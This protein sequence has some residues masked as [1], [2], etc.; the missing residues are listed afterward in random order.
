M[1]EFEIDLLEIL[2]R[3]AAAVES[4]AKNYKVSKKPNDDKKHQ[5]NQILG[6]RKEPDNVLTYGKNKDVVGTYMVYQDKDTRRI[7][8]KPR[9]PLKGDSSARMWLVNQ[10]KDY[11]YETLEDGGIAIEVPKSDKYGSILGKVSWCFARELK[12]VQQ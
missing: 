6:E 10:L 8:L 7:E 9:K 12:E 2:L 5:P 4:I 11:E 1:S 3:I